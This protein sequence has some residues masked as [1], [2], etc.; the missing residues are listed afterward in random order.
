MNE[1]Q[2]HCHCGNIH[3]TF[4]SM[5]NENDFTP[6]TCSCSFCRHHGGSYVSDPEGHIDLNFKDKTQVNFYQ[7]GQKTADFIIC[8][9]CG[10]ITMAISNIKDKNYAVIN[11]RA[12]LDYTFTGTATQTNFDGETPQQRLERRAQNWIGHVVI[13]D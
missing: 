9:N 4:S 7:F 1:F 8:K 6:R 11:I 10:V 3:F 13:K 2:G 5:N 12:M